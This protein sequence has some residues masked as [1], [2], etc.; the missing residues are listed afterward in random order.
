MSASST[1]RPFN[2]FII[3]VHSRCNLSCTYC[4]VYHMADQT[5]QGQPFRMSSETVLQ[6]AHRIT[7]H[8]TTH[9]LPAIQVVLHGG[10]PLLAGADFL[11]S[12]AT[13]I[14]AEVGSAARVDISLQTN[15]VLL[16]PPM[17]DVLARHA[18]GVGVSLDGLPADHDRR[19]V[20]RDGRGS[21]REVVAGL[22]V[23]TSPAYRHLYRGVLCT[24]D[25]TADPLATYRHLAGFAPP[26]MDLLLP[27]GNWSSP[28]P[29][30]TP[31]AGTPYADWLT[32][33]F[34]EWYDAPASRPR[35][36]LFE[37]IIQLALGGQ[38]RAESIGLTPSTLVVVETDGQIEQVDALKSAYQGAAATG[39]RVADDPFD[40]AL[41]HPAIAGR[42]DGLAGLSQQCQDCPVVRICGGGYY[43]HRYRDTSG[44]DNPSVYCPDLIELISHISRRLSADLAPLLSRS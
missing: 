43:P 38:S 10:E 40:A 28:P 39:L 16:A 34:D 21:Y 35:I 1:V 41:R 14:R 23:L 19:R 36:R 12:V 20:H 13:T 27:H 18:I 22:D 42:Q 17:L 24:I 2:Q 44:F 7:E 26:V 3:K 32:A 33:V 25:L 29:G 4:Y 11:G 9:Q 6:T 15:G 37:E 30:R 8:V 31:E 5:W